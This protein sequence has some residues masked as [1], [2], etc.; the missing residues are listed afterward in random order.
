MK[1]YRLSELAQEVIEDLCRRNPIS[2]AALME[3]C[4]EIFAQ[5]SA[6]GDEAIRLL[7]E[8]FDGVKPDAIRVDWERFVQAGK[9][10]STEVQEAL[11]EAARNI[12]KFHASQQMVEEAV[13]IRK[14]V[15][16]WRENRAIDSVGL[17][18]PGGNAVLPSTV[19]M[20]GI[21]A[22]LAG[23]RRIQLCVPPGRDGRVA[24]EVL[25]AAEIAGISD[26]FAI[27]GAQAIA[28]MTLGTES[29]PAVDK[30]VGPGTG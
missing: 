3:T 16:C 26:V 11:E 30:I 21:P 13:E 17:Y 28:A 29:V 4:R 20:L 7:T 14:G 10:I 23:C 15:L 6:D 25:V 27:G 18:V 1:S 9:E 8:R 19:L 22:R 24:S 12:K 2:D 5:V